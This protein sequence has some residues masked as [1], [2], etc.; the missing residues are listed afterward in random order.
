MTLQYLKDTYD[1]LTVEQ[2]NLVTKLMNDPVLR[3]MYMSSALTDTQNVGLKHHMTESPLL[4]PKD[5]PRMRR[6]SLRPFAVVRISDLDQE[7]SDYWVQCC[8]DPSCSSCAES[9]YCMCPRP[10]K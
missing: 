10:P 1:A 7:I 5:F 9:N 3:F 4:R 2:Q 6:R 8:A